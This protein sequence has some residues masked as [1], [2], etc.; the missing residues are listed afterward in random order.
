MKKILPIITIACF[1]LMSACAQNKTS[2]KSVAAYFTVSIPGMQ[3]VDENGNK[4]NPQPFFT[5]FLYVETKGKAKPFFD[6]ISYNGSLYSSSVAVDSSTVKVGVNVKD[7]TPIM[8]KAVK[9]NAIW[10]IDLQPLNDKQKIVA[11]NANVI[12]IKGKVDKTAFKINLKNEI[13]LST[14]DMY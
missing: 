1:L 9:G 13:E 6:T 12:I 3:R 7:G 2:I 14:P 8:M 10:R 5:R 11:A 4:I